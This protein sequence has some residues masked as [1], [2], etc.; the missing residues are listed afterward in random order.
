MCLID[1]YCM[2]G[3]GSFWISAPNFAIS[4]MRFVRIGNVSLARL[5]SA[6]ATSVSVPLNQCRVLTAR[7]N[8]SDLFVLISPPG[9][10]IYANRVD[11]TGCLGRWFFIP[12]ND[13]K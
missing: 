12:L 4:A 8:L 11:G 5:A 9:A 2:Y 10:L 1:L 7:L 6:S 13:N 3:V